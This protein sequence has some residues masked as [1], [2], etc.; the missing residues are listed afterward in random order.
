MP[1]SGAVKK[2]LDSPY[3]AIRTKGSMEVSAK[4]KLTSVVINISRLRNREPK[5]LNAIL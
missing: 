5:L 1:S 4:L 3:R 2:S